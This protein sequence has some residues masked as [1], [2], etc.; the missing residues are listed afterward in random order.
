MGFNTRANVY[1]SIVAGS[2]SFNAWVHCKGPC[3][4]RF[5]STGGLKR[6]L[7]Q[8]PLCRSHAIDEQSD[9][10]VSSDE[11]AP[12][13]SHTTDDDDERMDVDP[14]NLEP[15]QE[16]KEEEEPRHPLGWGREDAERASH[17]GNQASGPDN[18]FFDDEEEEEDAE[19]EEG[20]RRIVDGDLEDDEVE[21]DDWTRREGG[22]DGGGPDDPG[23]G[24]GGGNPPGD[25]MQHPLPP[26]G[27]RRIVRFGGRAGEIING[28]AQAIDGYR[29]YEATLPQEDGPDNPYHPFASK[30]DWDVA[31][32]AKQ[33]NIGSNALT[34]L[35]K[36]D[37]V[38]WST[39]S[40]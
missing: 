32:W 36:I 8:K 28:W 10:H 16:E 24:G 30:M 38:R 11:D 20:E 33:F 31:A 25:A 35:L 6:H 14:D 1:P 7:N 2:D 26:Q 4:K 39:T 29:A 27:K 15:E 22:G 23:G 19:E 5:R 37:G 18:V 12:D 34:A 21:D 40:L 13:P 3:G 9:A 17:V